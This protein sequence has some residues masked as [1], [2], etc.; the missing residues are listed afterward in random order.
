VAHQQTNHKTHRFLKSHHGSNQILLQI[1]EINKYKSACYIPS[2]FNWSQAEKEYQKALNLGNTRNEIQEGIISLEKALIFHPYHAMARLLLA[3]KLQQLGDKFEALEQL[4][5]FKAIEKYNHAHHRKKTNMR[6][7]LPCDYKLTYQFIP[8]YA[9]DYQTE[10]NTD[11]NHWGALHYKNVLATLILLF[12]SFVLHADRNRANHQNLFYNAYFLTKTENESTIDVNVTNP[13]G[14]AQAGILQG[15]LNDSLVVVDSTFDGNEQ[16]MIDFPVGIDDYKDLGEAF[17][18]GPNPMHSTGRVYVQNPKGELQL[19]NSIGQ[20]LDAANVA[21]D[22]DL[23][24]QSMPVPLILQYKTNE[25][26]GTK[27][28]IN[29]GKGT[30]LDVIVDGQAPRARLKS[31]LAENFKLVYTDLAGNVEDFT[32]TMDVERGQSYQVSEDVNWT[33]KENTVFGRMWGATDAMVTGAGEETGIT[34]DNQGNF[35]EIVQRRYDKNKG[36]NVQVD[37]SG[38]THSNPWHYQANLGANV[39]LEI[40]DTLLFDYKVQGTAPTGTNIKI[41]NEKGRFVTQAQTDTYETDFTIKAPKGI[42]STITATLGT[43]EKEVQREL[44]PGENQIAFSFY[45]EFTL[46]GKVNDEENG[47][48]ITGARLTAWSKGDSILWAKTDLEGKYQSN[49]HKDTNQTINIDSLTL[50][51]HPYHDKTLEGMTLEGEEQLDAQMKKR[52]WANVNLQGKTTPDAYLRYFQQG[53]FKGWNIIEEDSTFTSP[54]ITGYLPLDVQID[55]TAPTSYEDTNFTYTAT[56]EG[57][58]ELNFLLGKFHNK[59]FLTGNVTDNKSGE[60]VNGATAIGWADGDTLIQGVTDA[61]GEYWTDTIRHLTMETM[62]LDSFT[63]AAAG[64][65]RFSM[66]DLNIPAGGDDQ[67]ARLVRKQVQNYPHTAVVHV[68]SDREEKNVLG[69]VAYAIDTHNNDTITRMQ[70]FNEQ[71]ILQW[72]DTATSNTYKIG[73]RNATRHQGS[74]VTKT[75]GAIDTTRMEL[76]AA[77]EWYNTNFTVTDQD[78]TLLQYVNVSTAG[79]ETLTDDNGNASIDS[80]LVET[81][82]FNRAIVPYEATASA[83]P[84]TQ[85]EQFASVAK[86]YTVDGNDAELDF[87]VN[88]AAQVYEY[89]MQITG[90]SSKTGKLLHDD[91]EGF[92]KLPGQDTLFYNVQNQTINA[93]FTSELESITNASYG[94]VRIPGHDNVSATTNLTGDETFNDELTATAWNYP[95]TFTGNVEKENGEAIKEALVSDG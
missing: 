33:V 71:A 1:K 41:E 20:L 58:N 64:Y 9:D 12:L 16:Y 25:G 82:G 81:D 53:N 72:E 94:F 27:K 15:Y 40:I 73:I 51:A 13:D 34:L 14:Q 49:T 78:G 46:T 30:H 88:V 29:H 75:I 43:L 26:M 62:P 21:T 6:D 42:Q 85:S 35:E 23:D 79:K 55:V 50:K 10:S 77:K 36:V 80:I 45:N 44:Q 83:K 48:A 56:K 47:T 87:M 18:V 60:G 31:T 93:N 2:Y 17:K 74:E 39:P 28:I 95:A 4:R 92:I 11:S 38:G 84:T 91:A 86:K 22:K 76:L 63:V 8:S 59:F 54:T 7:P 5:L 3:K 66:Q 32:K 69:G 65:E 68:S 67:D 19:F 57:T 61:T 37:F 52:T 89:T 24:A 70:V 90:Q